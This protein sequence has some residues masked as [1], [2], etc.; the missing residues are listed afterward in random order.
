MQSV[1]LFSGDA[2]M[3]DNERK[4]FSLFH[5][6]TMLIHTMTFHEFWK[7]AL[8][9]CTLHL[10]MMTVSRIYISAKFRFK[11]VTSHFHRYKHWSS[12][13]TFVKEDFMRP[14]IVCSESV[15]IMYTAFKHLP[16][17]IDR[18]I[19]LAYSG[20]RYQSFILLTCISEI[21][22]SRRQYVPL[23]SNPSRSKL[24]TPSIRLWINAKYLEHLCCDGKI[25]A[26]KKSAVN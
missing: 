3:Q 8:E 22:R 6:K 13:M 10:K 9:M 26:Y 20:Y 24:S 23:R 18:Q 4:V 2:R 15:K 19:F 5:A 7:S 1:T 21:S 25:F 12:F 17:I 11:N 16:V 14:R